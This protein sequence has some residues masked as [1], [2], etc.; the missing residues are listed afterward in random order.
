MKARNDFEP[1]PKEKFTVYGSIKNFD[2]LP[3]RSGGP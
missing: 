1:R 3:V 2:E